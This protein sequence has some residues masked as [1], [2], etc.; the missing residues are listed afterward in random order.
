[1][2]AEVA[3]YTGQAEL[4]QAIQ[5]G[6]EAKR[7][8][9]DHTATLKLGR[10]VQLAEAAGN[11]DTKRLL[12]K[13]VD[14]EDAATGTVRLKRQVETLDEMALDTRSTKTV[15]VHKAQP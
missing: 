11:D 3:H 12:A 1:M 8:G 13:V 14:V 4:A 2:N 10:A 15:R 6:L 7:V 9:D 5:E